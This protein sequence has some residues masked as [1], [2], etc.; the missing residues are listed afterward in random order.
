LVLF[1]RKASN[2]K[3]GDAS[4]EE[5]ANARQLKGVIV[6][7]PEKSSVVTFTKLSEVY[8]IFSYLMNNHQFTAL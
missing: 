8:F 5:L 4:K 3:K 7:A 1:P 2:P 6:A